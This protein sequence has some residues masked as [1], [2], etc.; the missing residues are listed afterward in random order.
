MFTMKMECIPKNCIAEDGDFMQKLINADDAI[1]VA[2]K[3]YNSLEIA[4]TN[5]FSKTE[6]RYIIKRQDLC[7]AVMEVIERCPAFDLNTNMNI[8][9]AEPCSDTAVALP[10]SNEPMEF[11]TA[12]AERFRFLRTSKKLTFSQIANLLDMK[13]N[14]Q[15]AYLEKGTGFPSFEKLNAIINLFGI[16]SDWLYGYSDV[17]YN[18]KLIAMKESELLSY[19]KLLPLPTS[20]IS[21]YQDKREE[22]FDWEERADII[23]LIQ[24][25]Q[26]DADKYLPLLKAKLS[27][28]IYKQIIQV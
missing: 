28:S 25:V 2:K 24:A 14:S 3:A 5:S 6:I 17:Q 4:K 26:K 22:L 21:A 20:L 11:K 27:Q 10:I 9:Q 12:F 16:S 19:L 15:I 18:N 7:K 8:E 23:F 1:E 13:S